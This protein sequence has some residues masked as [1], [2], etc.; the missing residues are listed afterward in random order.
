MRP[1]RKDLVKCYHDAGDMPMLSSR[2]AWMEFL[3]VSGSTSARLNELLEMDWL[4]PERTAD[5][6]FLFSPKDAYRLRKLERLCADFDLHTL[7][8]TIIVDLLAR[9]EELENQ[10]GK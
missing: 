8:G 7:A 2:M 9:I 4:H 1:E 10:H 5:E 3:E 6:S